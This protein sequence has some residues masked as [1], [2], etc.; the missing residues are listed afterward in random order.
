[1]KKTIKFLGIQLDLMF[2]LDV[3]RVKQLVLDI[4]DNADDVGLV[5]SNTHA[6]IDGFVRQIRYFVSGQT[7]YIDLPHCKKLNVV[8]ITPMYRIYDGAKQR[9]YNRKVVIDIYK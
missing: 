7:C 4:P 1:M 9:N 5:L 2:C 8:S 6:T 3:F